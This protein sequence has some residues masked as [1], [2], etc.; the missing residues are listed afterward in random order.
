MRR[1]TRTEALFNQI[2]IGGVWGKKEKSMVI[3]FEDLSESPG[4]VYRAVVED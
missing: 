4:L 3:A 2:E 1:L